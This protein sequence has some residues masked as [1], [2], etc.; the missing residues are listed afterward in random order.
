MITQ[1]MLNK[2]REF[3]LNT[4]EAKTW[5]AILMKGT[6]TASTLSEVAGVPRSRCYD[7]LESLEKKGFIIAKVGRPMKYI[8]VRP[9]EAV[10]RVKAQ[11]Q[12]S[13]E[14]HLESLDKLKVGPLMSELTALH[15]SGMDSVDPTELTGVIKQKKNVDSHLSSMI[16]SAKEILIATNASDFVVKA[17]LLQSLL[18]TLT[19]KPSIR[20]ITDAT[21]TLAMQKSLK[22][23]EIRVVKNAG[24]FFIADDAATLFLSDP[25]SEEAAIWVNSPDFVESLRDVFETKWARN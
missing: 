21:N 13:T 23:V 6:A 8:A 5:A 7:V 12:K 1:A 18:P 17:A 15:T 25:S 22:G 20:I 11:L 9:Q 14:E 2:L 4:Y 10:E 24:K 3:G 16:R 19:K